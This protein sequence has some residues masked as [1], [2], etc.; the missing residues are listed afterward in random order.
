[1]K[2]LIIGGNRFVGLRLSM[3]LQ[4][5]P[6]IELHIMNRTGQAPHAANAVIH[7]ADR[8]Y[9]QNSGLDSDW[10]VVFDFAGFQ[11]S[12]AESS[13][14]FFKNV[15]RYIF[16]STSM[17]YDYGL[18]H[19][20]TDFDAATFN[21]KSTPRKGQ[22][23]AYQE[24]KR[25]CEGVFAQK[26]DFETLSVRFPF[27][28]GADD[29]THRLSFHIE[30]MQ[31]NEPIFIPNPTAQFSL[32][33]SE[34]AARFLLWSINSKLT[35]AVNMASPQTLSLTQLLAQVEL[36]T[37]NKP[38]LARESTADNHSPYG[39]PRDLTLNVGRVIEAGY[40]PKSLMEWLPALI[41]LPD[42]ATRP[43][44]GYLH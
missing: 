20:E 8:R 31:A 11:P 39:V 41:T 42:L 34:D 12:E 30:K 44:K 19:N 32:V 26:A 43:A 40:K 16:I 9:L 36:A 35:G 3:L 29:Y 22:D 38:R 4:K 25:R 24:G 21:L 23:S 18:G 17:V 6:G 2:C 13:V 14:Q 7:K 28:L 5:E 37:G 33:D 15:K 10:D 1:M 27:I